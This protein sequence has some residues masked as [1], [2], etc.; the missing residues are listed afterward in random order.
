MVENGGDR[1]CCLSLKMDDVGGRRMVV[2]GVD[3][4]ACKYV[5][6]MT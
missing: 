2:V 4:I 6:N 5:Q 1:G 3:D